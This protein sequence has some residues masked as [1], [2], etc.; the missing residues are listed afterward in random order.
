[1]RRSIKLVAAAIAT[2]IGVAQAHADANLC[3]DPLPQT[4]RQAIQSRFP[5][6]VLPGIS[7]FTTMHLEPF[8]TIGQQCPALAM[9]DVDGDGTQDFGL[10]VQLS[11][12]DMVLLVARERKTGWLI[13]VVAHLG[14]EKRGSAYVSVIDAGRY[15]DRLSKAVKPAGTVPEVPRVRSYRAKAPGFVAGDMEIAGAT[16]AAFFHNGRKWV[17]LRVPD[18][19]KS[20]D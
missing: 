16:H 18:A 9:A 5:D 14:K 6:S 7:D 11:D 8:E 17:Y 13:E 10:L 4:L 2:G 19:R 12:G 3:T 15:E 20:D 1:M